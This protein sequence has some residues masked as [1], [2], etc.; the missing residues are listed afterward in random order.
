MVSRIKNIFY[1]FIF[2]FLNITAHN[3]TA[4]SGQTVKVIS[5]APSNT[6]LI[7]ELHAQNDLIG[8]SRFCQEFNK[9]PKSKVVGDF[10]S[11]NQEEIIKLKP[12]YILLVQGQ[13]RLQESLNKIT[14][15]PF[16]VVLLP[17]SQLKNISQN[18]I[19]IGTITNQ[20][21]LAQNKAKLFDSA[22]NE[23]KSIL[24][25]TN[26]PKVFFCIWCRPLITPGKNSFLADIIDTCGGTNIGD[27]F[28]RDYAV[29]N[30]EFLIKQ[31]PD[32]ILLGK[33]INVNDLITP[34]LKDYIKAFKL[35]QV[36]NY[37]QNKYLDYP[38]LKT[39][40][41]VYYLALKLHPDLKDKLNKW[42]VKYSNF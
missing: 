17:N 35:K 29:I 2:L 15:I 4:K 23:L 32:F 3:L 7:N 22:L 36:V 30:S 26:K 41:G 28:N 9:N 20:Q 33:D 27:S 5:L 8:I 13:E 37:P 39:I 24:K 11:Y 19:K 34:D 18:I 38:C 14:L 31:N 12:D 1:F 40:K 16:K 6:L 10:S 25:N 21:T 42:Y